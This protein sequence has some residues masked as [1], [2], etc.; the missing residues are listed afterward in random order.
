MSLHLD[1]SNAQPIVEAGEELSLSVIFWAIKH[2]NTACN[3]CE[4]ACGRIDGHAMFAFDRV[5]YYS[6]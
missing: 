5:A 6:F 1:R 4:I 2:H 3:V